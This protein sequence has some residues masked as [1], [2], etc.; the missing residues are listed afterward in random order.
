[1]NGVEILG[2]ISTNSL[3]AISLILIAVSVLCLFSGI[4]SNKEHESFSGFMVAV[5]VICFFVGAC[6]FAAGFSEKKLAK[7]SNEVSFI[8][9]QEHYNVVGKNGE[10]FLIEEKDTNK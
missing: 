3:L 1:M 2:S 4:Y 9:L 6:M 5:S 8:E 7:I 10:L